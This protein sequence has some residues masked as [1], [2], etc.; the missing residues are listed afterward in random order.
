MIYEINCRKMTE[1]G[2]AFCLSA[3]QIWLTKEVPVK[4]LKKLDRA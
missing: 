2:Y 3:N 1:D 4:Y